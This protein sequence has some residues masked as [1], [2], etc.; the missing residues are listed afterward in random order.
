MSKKRK[1]RKAGTNFCLLAGGSNCRL[2]EKIAKKLGVP[3]VKLTAT[4]FSDGEEHIEILESVRGKD[5]IIIQSLSHPQA[6]HFMELAL[7]IDA[8][9]RA[10]CR[11]VRVVMPYF[12]YARQ[13]RRG[14]KRYPIS[15][16]SVIQMLQT[17]GA[18]S[19]MT[20]EVHAPQIEGQTCGP[21]PFDNLYAS[22]VFL[23]WII[24]ALEGKKIVIVSP[25]AGGVERIRVY[26]DK[27]GV[28]LAIIHKRRSAPG[29]AEV[30][31]VVGEVAGMTCIIIDDMVDTAGTLIKGIDALESRGA[32]AVYA[33]ANHLV[34]S[35]PAIKRIRK[36]DALKLVVGTD[37]IHQPK[38][39]LRC[40]KI[41][42]LSVATI[43]ADAIGE[44]QKRRG[45]SVSRLFRK[46]NG[47]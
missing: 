16:S 17:A 30:M 21:V 22:P 1:S 13:D 37:T 28:R 33:I 35:G 32:V 23:A 42:L 43:F 2:A 11:S 4:Q 31:E 18:D 47:G 7:L 26:A 9:K 8:A 6:H 36:C 10:D 27:L 12:G 19:F 46:V 45:G 29:E 20:M 40:R 24:A 41:R 38:R 14:R 34:L 25:D 39:V 5:V 15:A 3:L 44:T